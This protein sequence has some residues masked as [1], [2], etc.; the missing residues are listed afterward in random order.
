MGSPR[1]QQLVP[2]QEQPELH[3]PHTSHPP[4]KQ[5]HSSVIPL[6]PSYLCGDQPAIKSTIQQQQILLA[7]Q[8]GVEHHSQ[9]QSHASKWISILQPAPPRSKT[10]LQQSA[11]IL[12]EPEL[13]PPSSVAEFRQLPGGETVASSQPH[14]QQ[15][16]V[17]H[18]SHLPSTLSHQQQK[19]QTPSTAATPTATTAVAP[20]VRG[21]YSSS[22][23]ALR[24][25]S[26]R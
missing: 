5:I 19:Q 17:S 8:Q 16:Q 7:E 13:A 9:A 10:D 26:L 22:F 3:L 1:D 25:Q 15:R 20:P 4:V 24:I 2:Q 23:H 14:P 6:L 21:G 12:S 18:T 11:H